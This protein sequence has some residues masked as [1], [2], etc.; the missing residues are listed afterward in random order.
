[1]S[2]SRHDR[3][4][5]RIARV[6][7]GRPQRKGADLKSGNRVMEIKVTYSDL[8]NAI[9][10]LKASRKPCKYVVVPSELRKKAI[11]TTKGTGIG[12]MDGNGRIVKRCR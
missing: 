11:S 12:V 8:Y 5:D 2:K 7:G 9:G 4:V 10:Q 1:M 3:L 6:H